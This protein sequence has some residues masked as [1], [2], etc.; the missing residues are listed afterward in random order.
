MATE[1]ISKK[2]VFKIA[3]VFLLAVIGLSSDLANA[4]NE[5]SEEGRSASDKAKRRRYPG[6]KDE[7]ELTV[8]AVLPVTSRYP[9]DPK[10]APAA[11]SKD[12]P[13]EDLH[14]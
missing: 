3:A 12:Q 2:S 13:P 5:E 1:M 7:Q 8:Q 4:Q 6:G 14:D 10:V 11:P 9:Q